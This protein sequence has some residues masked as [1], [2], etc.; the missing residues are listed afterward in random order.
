MNFA[1]KGSLLGHC[2]VKISE[3]DLS[4]TDGVLILGRRLGSRQ[5]NE[6]V[7]GLIGGVGHL[8]SILNGGRKD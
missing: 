2:V 8:T 1:V 7:L 6:S 3:R 5:I 4:I